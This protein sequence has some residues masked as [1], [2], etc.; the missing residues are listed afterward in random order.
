MKTKAAFYIVFYN[1]DLTMR[2]R[3]FKDKSEADTFAKQKNSEAIL[4]TL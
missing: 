4:I 2:E 3:V 1:D